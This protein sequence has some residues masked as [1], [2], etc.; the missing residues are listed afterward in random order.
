MCTVT[1]CPPAPPN[2]NVERIYWRRRA[3]MVVYFR[4]ARSM[5]ADINIEIGGRGGHC[6]IL[7]HIWLL[8]AVVVFSGNTGVDYHMLSYTMLLLLSCRSRYYPFHIFLPRSRHVNASAKF[9]PTPARLNLFIPP[10]NGILLL[11]GVWLAFRD[12]LWNDVLKPIVFLHT[13]AETRCGDV[14]KP[15]VFFHT[16]AWNPM[17]F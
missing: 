5:D 9:L 13:I 7:I 17:I 3:R 4:I 2:F 11:C 15:V 1:G 10:F 8:N 14:L 6:V 12:N 16:L